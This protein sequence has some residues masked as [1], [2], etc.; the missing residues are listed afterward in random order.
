MDDAVNT[1]VSGLKFSSEK[2]EL[3]YN[4]IRYI[5]IRPATLIQ[6]Q[7]LLEERFGESISELMFKA[8]HDIGTLIGRR[9][10]EQSGLSQQ[11]MITSMLKSAN[12]LGWGKLFL[13]KSD[14]YPHK[15]VLEAVNSVFAETYGRSPGPVCHLIRGIFCGALSQIVGPIME[16]REIECKSMDFPKCTFEFRMVLER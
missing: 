8:A 14:E 4:N 3:L 5:L 12:E 2:G 7:K 6:F 16:S 15:V 1:I 9:L 13:K 10:V 11:E